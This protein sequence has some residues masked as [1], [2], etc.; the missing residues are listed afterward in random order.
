MRTLGIFNA[1][2][3][4]AEYTYTKCITNVKYEYVHILKYGH[5]TCVVHN[6]LLHNI[7]WTED[8]I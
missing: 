7:I 2:N 4:H 8:T 6:L 5:T 3:M 1:H